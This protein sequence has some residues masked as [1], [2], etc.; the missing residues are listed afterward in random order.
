VAVQD[1]I[2]RADAGDVIRL[3]FTGPKGGGGTKA[4]TIKNNGSGYVSTNV[5][6]SLK[7]VQ[8]N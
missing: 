4:D 6:A 5:S 2:F 7:I 8:I 3:Q 1:L